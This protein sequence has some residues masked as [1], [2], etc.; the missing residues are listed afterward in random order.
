MKA[1]RVIISSLLWM[2]LTS[3][4]TWG[5]DKIGYI[6]EV[7]CVSRQ[8]LQVIREGQIKTPGTLM[9][10]LTGDQLRI[11]PEA[12]LSCHA[13]PSSDQKPRVLLSLSGQTVP[14][15]LSK[16]PQPLPPTPR[17]S[18][19]DHVK[20]SVFTWFSQDHD[21]YFSTN[22]ATR[23]TE[24]ENALQI[25]LLVNREQLFLAGQRPLS[26]YW[27]GGK[28]PYEIQLFRGNDPAPFYQKTTT[29]TALKIDPFPLS[30]GNYWVVLHDNENRSL[31]TNFWVVPENR[32][33]SMP[34]AF[35]SLD[36]PPDLKTTLEA[37]WLAS[38][39]HGE[40]RLEAL[41]RVEPLSAEFEPAMF[42]KTA[43]IEGAS[44]FPKPLP[45]GE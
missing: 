29:S 45:E 24:D 5:A 8:E 17:M 6:R 31:E 30:P 10:L 16:T 18:V 7:Y 23:T 36:A 13:K 25:P 1:K 39:H 41:T 14:L 40:W 42:L 43:L 35:Q 20:E 19:F 2:S 32:K 28:A 15:V 33:P 44:Y 12:S 34:Q 22:T 38:H 11:H 27:Q 4:F 9:P 37:L 26:L 3:G 21:R